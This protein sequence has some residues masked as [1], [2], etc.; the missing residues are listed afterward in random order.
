MKGP[1]GLDLIRSPRRK[2]KRKPR[3]DCMIWL[4][5][6]L[7]AF[8][9]T[10]PL[11]AHQTEDVVYLKNGSIVRGTIVE[12]VPD[13]SLK[14]Q[15]Q[16]GSVFVYERDEI[17]R[18][19][20]KPVA[21]MVERD[22]MIEI[23]TLFGFFDLS[24]SRGTVIGLPGG[25]LVGDLIG[26]PS[27]YVLWYPD[28]KLSLGPEFSLIRVSDNGSFSSLYFGGRV[29]VF[30][31]GNA[32]SGGYMSGQVAL[33]HVR[34]ESSGG[35]DDSDTD[36]SMGAGLGYQWRIR[37]AFVLGMEGRYQRWF[38]EQFNVFSLLLRM[39]TRLGGRETID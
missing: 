28:K 7:V 20:R 22:N 29:A 2:M 9:A 8:A 19:E 18:I 24:D 38:E 12:E 6:I 31:K 34:A 14:I 32:V 15:M 11:I 17:A 1:H 13:E 35:W 21:R 25:G 5:F 23:G 10:T 4:C 33:R 37:S 3:K 16:D 30:P 26:V 36:F 39:S 27:L